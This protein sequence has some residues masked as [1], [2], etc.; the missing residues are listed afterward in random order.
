MC[1]GI[2]AALLSSSLAT[3]TTSRP[4][5]SRTLSRI[6]TCSSVSAPPFGFGIGILLPAS[7]GGPLLDEDL[8]FVHA[9]FLSPLVDPSA[10]HVDDA[11]VRLA[12]ALALVEHLAAREQCVARV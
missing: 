4:A 7:V 1:A 6:W 8:P 2:S 3:G 9:D 5:K 10:A 12:P 11:A